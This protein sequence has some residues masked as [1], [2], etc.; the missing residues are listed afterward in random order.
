[1]AA[2]LEQAHDDWGPIWPM[3]IAPYHVQICSLNP[4]KE[5]V[6]EATDKLY[7]ELLDLGIEVLYDDRGEKAGFMFNDADLSGI[8][9][10]LIVSPKTLE[11]NQA[12]YK[13]RGIRDGEMLNL[14]EA[15]AKT[16]AIVK[17]ALQ[18]FA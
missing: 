1:M 7:Q 3:S 14:D 6:K 9:Y 15:A 18:K 2:V 16:A 17:E 8:P 5:G 11:Q 12:E 10:R 4:K 13:I